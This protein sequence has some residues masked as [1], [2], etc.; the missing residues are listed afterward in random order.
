M[1]VQG[2]GADATLDVLADGA[3]LHTVNGFGIHRLPQKET[4]RW[5]IRASGTATIRNI[6][7]ATSLS[8]LAGGRQ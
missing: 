4:D 3:I 2:E 7:L 6:K 5:Q 8:D 1:E